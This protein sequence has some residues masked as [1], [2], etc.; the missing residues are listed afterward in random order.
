MSTDKFRVRVKYY[1]TG[2]GLGIVASYF[3]FGSRGCEWLPGNRVK[4]MIGE[5]AIVIGDS[6]SF[7][8]ECNDL[9]ETEIYGLLDAEGDVVFAESK[10]D[11]DPKEYRIQGEKEGKEFWIRYALYDTL[12]EVISF[13]YAS[14]TN[15]ETSISNDN[16]KLVPLPLKD[17]LRIIESEEFRILETA[18]CQM[19]CYGLTKKEV[20]GFH[21]L[22]DIYVERSEPR[23]IPNPYYVLHVKTEKGEFS[24][25]YII[26]E[27][28]TRISDIKGTADC[29]C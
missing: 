10:T 18:Q 28:R 4:N 24:V 5:K 25:T 13:E 12:S 20:L 29:G 19:D 26:G 21:R 3:F 11:E 7:L 15:C 2:L 22:E 9:D 16:K 17:V 1:L 6:L 14:G 27:N 23:L 8:M